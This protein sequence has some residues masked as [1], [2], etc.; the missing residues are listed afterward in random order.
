MTNIALGHLTYMICRSLTKEGGDHM[1]TVYVMSWFCFV[2]QDMNVQLEKK[3]I[4]SLMFHKTRQI[5]LRSY[6]H[7]NL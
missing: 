3:N 1:T 7:T 6:P 2:E 4:S 5:P